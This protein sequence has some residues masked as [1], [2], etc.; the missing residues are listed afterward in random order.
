M[1]WDPCMSNVQLLV[2]IAIEVLS[3]ELLEVLRNG[4]RAQE[5]FRIA[6]AP[7]VSKRFLGHRIT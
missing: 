2:L 1:N 5:R 4:K 3:D 6:A 7:P